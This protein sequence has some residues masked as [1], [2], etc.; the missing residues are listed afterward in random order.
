MPGGPLV[1]IVA[2]LIVIVLADPLDWRDDS[3]SSARRPTPQPTLTAQVAPTVTPAPSA[4][5]APTPTPA[6]QPTPTS[7]VALAEMAGMRGDAGW[8]C[9]PAQVDVERS[10]DRPGVLTF[11][12]LAVDIWNNLADSAAIFR[13]AIPTPLT[14]E[15]ALASDEF[16]AAASV[17]LEEV[18]EEISRLVQ[19]RA[20]GIPERVRPMSLRLGDHLDLERVVVQRFVDAVTTRNPVSW[21]EAIGLLGRFP[22]YESQVI[23]E[24][25]AVCGYLQGE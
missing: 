7:T 19:G 9:P 8:L 6:P 24:I 13:A 18:N 1:F 3:S 15:A 20:A 10:P 17:H 4:T 21:N 12:N 2:A 5:V 23:V 25:T 22:E 14:Y 11:W 16:S